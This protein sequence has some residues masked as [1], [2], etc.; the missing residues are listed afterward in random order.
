MTNYNTLDTRLICTYL[1]CAV[2]QYRF[3][4]NAL[5]TKPE[6]LCGVR[7]PQ[8]IEP[9]SAPKKCAFTLRIKRVGAKK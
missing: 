2:S 6:R 1:S 7:S 4:V 5:T 3:P 9:T 8:S